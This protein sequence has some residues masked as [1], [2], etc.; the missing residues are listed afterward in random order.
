MLPNYFHSSYLIKKILKEVLDLFLFG[1]KFSPIYTKL[2]KEWKN[3]LI[4]NRKNAVIIA[5]GS[6]FSNSLANRIIEYRDFFDVFSINFY[7]LNEI[8]EK[9]V[10]DYYVISD[11]GN[12]CIEAGDPVLVENNRKLMQY[13][14]RNNCKLICP[15][16]KEWIQ[17]Y[18]P[19]LVF[20]DREISSFTFYKNITPLLPRSYTS[21]TSFK[22][23]AVALFMKY[24]RIFLFGLDYNYPKKIFLDE[25][26]KL[27]LL[28]EH[29][30]GVVNRDISSYYENVGHALNWWSKDYW[31]VHRLKS[32]RLLNV[33]DVSL[34]DCFQR[35][36]PL[37]FISKIDSLILN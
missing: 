13:I 3:K 19:Y 16:T 22:A 4:K 7:C 28:D 2:S 26:N 37:E 33:T 32:D 12:L 30:Y 15:Y 10:P 5:G 23:I 25:E 24:E 17:K 21:N 35:I 6:S 27:F 29:H 8:S 11:P 31:T 14:K 36:T 20:D 9:L 18:N 1:H 34:I